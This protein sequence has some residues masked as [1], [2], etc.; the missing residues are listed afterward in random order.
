MWPSAARRNL[1]DPLPRRRHRIKGAGLQLMWAAET[2]D[3]LDG[4]LAQS[5]RS[6]DERQALEACLL[7]Q[8]HPLVP[9]PLLVV[10]DDHLDLPGVADIG[11]RLVVADRLNAFEQARPELAAVGEGSPLREDVAMDA[12][13]ADRQVGL[14]D[15]DVV[16]RFDA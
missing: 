1:G 10:V 6:R 16:G 13:P 7:R 3:V 12:V 8:W 15:V 9:D 5:R 11:G 2:A 4:Q 14:V